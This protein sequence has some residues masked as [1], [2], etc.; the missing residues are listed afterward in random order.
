MWP[1]LGWINEVNAIAAAPGGQGG[2]EA[3]GPADVGRGPESRSIEYGRIHHMS[4]TVQ[5]VEIDGRFVRPGSGAEHPAA[6]MEPPGGGEGDREGIG[7]HKITGVD[8]ALDGFPG[9]RAMPFAGTW[10]RGERLKLRQPA[11]PAASMATIAVA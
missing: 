11:R 9:C 5:K 6:E 4:G 7:Q 3:L 10:G 2:V 1:A 8:R